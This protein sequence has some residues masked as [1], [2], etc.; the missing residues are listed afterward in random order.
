M[1][2]GVALVSCKAQI[3]GGTGMSMGEEKRSRSGREG[4]ASAR[5]TSSNRR[6]GHG[7]E[8]ASGQP[9]RAGAAGSARL[10]KVRG[11]W[12]LRCGCQGLCE[13][14]R[15]GDAGGR[16]L[17]VVCVP[18]RRVSSDGCRFPRRRARRERRYLRS[19]PRE[20]RRPRFIKERTVFPGTS[21]WR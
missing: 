1:E 10:P 12:I 20:G 6:R 13:G 19:G 3:M 16:P 17:F 5:S 2:G 21:L 7:R 14:A 4:N 8:G 15:R 9:R 11:P 18:R